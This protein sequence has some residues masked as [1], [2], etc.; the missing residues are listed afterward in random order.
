MGSISLASLYFSC[1]LTPSVGRTLLHQ[2]AVKN[3][4]NRLAMGQS[5]ERNSSIEGPFFRVCI[6][7]TTNL[8]YF[9]PPNLPV[10]A[11]SLVLLK[12]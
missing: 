5:D 8:Q 10:D 3:M 2:L 1:T 7:L 6:K 11:P 12:K 9:N 4:Y